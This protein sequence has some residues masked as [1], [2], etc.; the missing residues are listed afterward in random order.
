MRGENCGFVASMSPFLLSRPIPVVQEAHPDL[1]NAPK[2]G[3][4]VDLVVQL[5]ADG[6]FAQDSEQSAGSRGVSARLVA[7]SA[8]CNLHCMES[9][10]HLWNRLRS[11]LLTGQRHGFMSTHAYRLHLRHQ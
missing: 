6:Q 9:S 4:N 10:Q 11:I 8:S 5:T 3:P 7:L 2:V 1:A